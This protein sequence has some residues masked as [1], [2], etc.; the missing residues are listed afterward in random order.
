MPGPNKLSASPEEED[1]GC[2]SADQEDFSISARIV[3][4]HHEASSGGNGHSNSSQE[5]D[6]DIVHITVR[7]NRQDELNGEDD[8]T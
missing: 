6:T 5:S 7:R 8:L 4:I 3:W 1:D 2:T